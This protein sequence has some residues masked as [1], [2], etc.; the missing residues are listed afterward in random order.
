MKYYTR[1]FY[2]SILPYYLLDEFTIYDEASIYDDEFY[3]TLAKEQTTKLKYYG[4]HSRSFTAIAVKLLSILPA[5]IE[6]PDIR[7]FLLYAISPDL[8]AN[9]TDLNEKQKVMIQNKLNI[10]DNRYHEDKNVVPKHWLTLYDINWFDSVLRIIEKKENEISLIIE[11]GN[12]FK[13]TLQFKNVVNVYKEKEYDSIS[14]IIFT[15]VLYEDSKL[16]LNI[17]THSN[18]YSFT[19]DD[20]DIVQATIEY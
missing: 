10:I 8:H 18:E 7:T 9:I 5:S 19:A 15:E 17:M 4:I 6:I 13:Y 14:R 20:V 16:I 12:F 2:N 1:N 11:D 3:S